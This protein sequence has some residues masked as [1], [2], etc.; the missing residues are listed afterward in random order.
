VGDQPQRLTPGRSGLP[1]PSIDR[2]AR[3]AALRR[4]SQRDVDV[5]L[6]RSR[7]LPASEIAREL[8]ISVDE[9]TT[10][11]G[12]IYDL[13][14]L[15]HLSR[16]RRLDRLAEYGAA[17]EDMRENDPRPSA[18]DQPS[19]ATL[20][21][22]P[23]STALR[24][25]AADDQELL[26]T[27]PADVVADEAQP[28]DGSLAPRSVSTPGLPAAVG[29]ARSR[30]RWP[31]LATLLVAVLAVGAV[32]GLLFA[33]DS[34]DP[35]RT[36]TPDLAVAVPTQTPSAPSSPTVSATTATLVTGAAP[37]ATG[38]PAPTAT[39]T[40]T[41]PATATAAPTATPTEPAPTPTPAAVY[42]ADWS[43]GLDGWQGSGAWYVQ[44]GELISTGSSTSDVIYAPVAPSQLDAYAMEAEV[45]IEGIPGALTA[46]GFAVRGEGATSDRL[47]LGPIAVD[48]EW[49]VLRLEVRG[50]TVA[51]LIDGAIVGRITDPDYVRPATVGIAT[52]GNA[53]RVRRFEIVPL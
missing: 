17:A 53:L 50:D 40:A 43:D 28:P 24:A 41:R 30:A 45:K 29:S 14:W 8:G 2:A 3:I 13:L 46:V 16:E 21:L 20:T 33:R 7:G 47:S 51:F 1:G 44:D 10:R 39:R 37:T 5:V 25:V 11:L 36:P 31:L 4:L 42:T 6:L 15:T 48:D 38:T 32:V 9:A 12:H 49:H 22:M 18:A 35:A 52:L 27:R 26:A 23:P 34:S 19:L